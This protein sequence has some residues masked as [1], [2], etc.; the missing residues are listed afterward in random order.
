MLEPLTKSD[1]AREPGGDKGPCPVATAAAALLEQCAQFVRSA[2]VEAYSGPSRVLPG[3]TIGK[4]IRHTLDHFHAALGALHAG[5]LIDYDHRE[6]D[7]PMESDPLEALDAIESLRSRILDL[8]AADLDR[9]VRIRVMVSGDGLEAELGS[10][11]GRE[12]AFAS[13][14]AVHH[15]AMLGAIAAEYGIAPGAEFGRAP[16][17]VHYEM[18]R[19]G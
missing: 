17:T 9:P 19:S 8:G 2:S 7:V 1:A 3:G 18:G 15:Q 11:L 12:L 5:G 16:S 10:T 4:H 13:H 14:H 6:R